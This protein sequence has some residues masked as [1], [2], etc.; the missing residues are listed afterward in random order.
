MSDHETPP[1]SEIALEALK[2]IRAL[3]DDLKGSD[4][5]HKWPVQQ[6]DQILNVA[7]ARLQMAS[8]VRDRKD[9]SWLAEPISTT[10]PRELNSGEGGEATTSMCFNVRITDGAKAARGKKVEV[11]MHPADALWLGKNMASMASRYQ[12]A[13]GS[14]VASRI[15]PDGL[16]SG[17]PEKEDDET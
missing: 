5:S 1:R 2:E 3:L 17:G 8:M 11:R 7:Y 4:W 9:A 13:P 10:W 14:K 12:G 16:L 15:S 6:V